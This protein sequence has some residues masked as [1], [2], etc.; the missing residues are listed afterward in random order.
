[1]PDEIFVDPELP[2]IFIK[3]AVLNPDPLWPWLDSDL[4]DAI[5]ASDQLKAEHANRLWSDIN[6][7]DNPEFPYVV[8]SVTTDMTGT[9]TYELPRNFTGKVRAL[10]RIKTLRYFS[11]GKGSYKPSTA[12]YGRFKTC[13]IGIPE[14]PI[15]DDGN[16]IGYISQSVWR[17]DIK[18]GY[19]EPGSQA[20]IT[21]YGIEFLVTFHNNPE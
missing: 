16:L 17:D 8:W 18:K 4:N 15:I 11:S 20:L 19:R 6:V 9:A 10:C 7:G 3:Q 14:T 1:M 2:S 21:E 12:A 5:A 13:L